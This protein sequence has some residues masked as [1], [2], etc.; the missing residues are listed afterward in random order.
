MWGSREELGNKGQVGLTLC[1]IRE[2]CELKT[3]IFM[4]DKDG[5][6]VVMRLEQVSPLFLQFYISGFNLLMCCCSYSHYRSVRKPSLLRVPFYRRELELNN[7]LNYGD[8]E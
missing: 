1:S 4:F 6:F 2:F 3:P 7:I 8:F 5:A